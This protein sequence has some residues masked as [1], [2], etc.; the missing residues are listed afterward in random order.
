LKQDTIRYERVETSFNNT[1]IM[2][3]DDFL[4]ASIKVGSTEFKPKTRMIV[5][6]S[7][8]AVLGGIIA[9]IY[10][11]ISNAMRRRKNN[12]VKA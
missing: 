12:S 2:K 10:L 5:M 4:A 9:S 1:P 8:G 11:L 6:F 7:L 3:G